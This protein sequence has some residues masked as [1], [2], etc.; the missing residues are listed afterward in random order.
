MNV[1]KEKIIA[2]I[3]KMSVTMNSQSMG[4][5]PIIK[6]GAPKNAEKAAKNIKKVSYMNLFFK[7]SP[8]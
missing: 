1:I 6:I 5:L 4:L 2:V 7:I 8:F 3:K